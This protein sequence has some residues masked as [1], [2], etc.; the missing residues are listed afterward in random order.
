IFIFPGLRDKKFLKLCFILK[1][2]NLGRCKRCPDVALCENFK[3]SGFHFFRIEIY[4]R[5]LR[6]FKTVFILGNECLIQTAVRM[7][8]QARVQTPARED[9]SVSLYRSTTIRRSMG[10]IL[11]PVRG[12]AAADFFKPAACTLRRS[13]SFEELIVGN[14]Y[15]L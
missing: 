15:L 12:V 5:C 7:Q 10:K 4:Y 9:L 11:I 14:S 6:R 8:L 2:N 13:D 1:D 3:I